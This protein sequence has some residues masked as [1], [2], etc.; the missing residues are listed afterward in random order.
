MKKDI[1]IFL[2]TILLC[3]PGRFLSQTYQL[4]GNPVNTTGWDL[5]SDAIVSGDF[6]RL[7]TD[8]TS[9]YG[10]VKL[11][12]P[13]TLSY[14]D[15]WKVEFDFRI[16]GNGT[17]QFGKGDGFTFWY[18]ANPP[19]GFVS[20]GGL[21]IPANASGLMVGFD[22]FNNTTE[23]QMSKVHILYGTNNTA[24][25]NIEFNTTPGSTF[26]SPDLIATQPFVGDT[27]RHVEVNGETDLT[28]PTNW[29]IKVRINGVLIVDQSFAPS[30]GAVGMSQGYFGFSAATG[31]A[32]ARH[33][34]KD[35]KVYVDKVPILSN[36]IT[37]FVCT[38][39]AT[40]NG[41]VDL[42]SYNSQFVNNPG[43]YIFTY[44]VLGSSTPI[45]N[46]TSFQYSGNTT[47][48]VVVKDPT[49]TLCDNGDGVI[50]LNPT[51][52][53][54]TDATLSGC[55]NNNAGTATFDLNTAAVTTVAGVTKEFYPTLY[56][57]NNG[58]NQITNPSA[59]ASA[60]ATIYVK[61]T[62]PQGCV[63]TSKI[64]LNIY[65]VV[66]VNDVE[67]KSCFIE[68]NP[69]MA[70]FNLTGAVVSQGGLT[71]EYYP[72][73]TDAISGTNAISTPAAYI[74]PNG[75]VYIKVF[76]GNGCYSI[77]KV[78]LT[79]IP[80]VYSRTLLDKTICIENTTTLDAGAGFKSYEWSTG[81]TTQSIKNVGV[82]TYWVKLKTGDCIATQKVTVYPSDNP[83]ITTV[84]ISGSTVTVYANGGTPPYQ[85]SMDNINWQDSNVFTNIARGEAKVYVRDAY[86]CVPVEV[87]ITVPNLINIITPNDDGINDFVDYSALANKQNLEIAI[88]D[89]YGYKMFQA[90]KTNGYKWAG[91]TN[92]HKKVP[93]GN[94]WYSVSWNENNKNSTPIKFSGWIVVKN[95]E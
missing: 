54:A 49:S 94:Y 22:I 38:N 45:A 8:Q 20:G 95:R 12:T 70:S 77:A 84:D 31:G 85:Y 41:T 47:I 21:G 48:K 82:G 58:T 23:G 6:V 65:P 56:D 37:P 55:N 17:T 26:H 28:N 68:T 72:S 16:D 87:N 33:S 43:N 15:K 75:V 11:S 83:V 25:N 74:A 76:N 81:A 18:L 62:T 73:L 44:Y 50:Q 52:F 78:T 57:L 36:T 67:L 80:P 64:T 32:S 51:P 93:T 19:T 71:K 61:V 35:V 53:A 13:I 2:L 59:Y 91:T 24:G 42:T 27:Y 3:L 79:V 40:G 63:S 60:A 89:R 86:N 7:T 90:D 1:L 92:G 46:P 69:S 66:V 88:F 29:I 30:G 5:V 34:I 9:R 14:C 4:T 39:P 10:A